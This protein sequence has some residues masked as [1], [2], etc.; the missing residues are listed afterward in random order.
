MC[1]NLK[2][3][4]SSLKNIEDALTRMSDSIPRI[5]TS[6]ERTLLDSTIDK[7]SGLAK[8]NIGCKLNLTVIKYVLWVLLIAI[9]A[10]GG[11]ILYVTL[12]D[13]NLAGGEWVLLI[14]TFLLSF[15]LII[16]AYCLLFKE[17]GMSSMPS[18]E[19]YKHLSHIADVIRDLY[20]I[21]RK[22]TPSDALEVLSRKMI[23]KDDLEEICKSK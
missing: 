7:L 14:G 9:F 18:V 11:V 16:I 8:D 17:S 1:K 15:L 6:S 21:E 2:E 12:D 3:V 13:N 20:E 22:G 19:Y 10:F 5:V 23:T 4:L